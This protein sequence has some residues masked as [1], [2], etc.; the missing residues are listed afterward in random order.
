MHPHVPRFIERY[1]QRYNED[2]LVPENF[3][4]KLITTADDLP[5]V[6][7]GRHQ[8]DDQTVYIFQDIVFSDAG[9]ELAFNSPL[10]GY[11]GGISGFVHTDGGPAIYGRSG[12]VFA[13]DLFVSAPSGQVLNIQGDTTN[14]VLV[15]SVSFNTGNGIMSS[16][17][18]L[19]VIDGMRVPTFLDCNFG[20]FDSGL[21]FTGPPDKVFVS[22]SPFRE[23]SEPGVTVLEFDSEFSTDIV[24]IVDS[25]VKGVQSD[26]VVV[27]F[28]SAATFTETFG[29]RGMSHDG[30]VTEAN[31]LTEGVEVDTVGVRVANSPPIPNSKAF[32]SYTLDSQTTTTINTQTASR[33][34][35]AAYERVAG[36]TTTT[37]NARFTTG[38]NTAEYLGKRGRVIS[39]TATTS[40]STGTGDVVVA[41][42]FVNGE[43]IPSSAV[44]IQ[45]NQQGGGVAKSITAIGAVGDI[46]TGDTYDVRLANLDSTTDIDV[47]ELNAQIST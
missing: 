43:L 38:D 17:A 39:L 18:D 29:Y 11:H 14:E 1:L 33:D 34:D 24:E 44:R 40:L 41:A 12:N 4:P 20:G 7:N 36:A 9:L 25:Y 16:I 5:P 45:M 46:D 37:T 31:V 13:R 15:E 21:T 35:G 2:N 27:R 8:L 19:G 42:W 28:D 23:V 10:I 26:T 3:Q 30:T 47:G 6:E 32:V 22:R